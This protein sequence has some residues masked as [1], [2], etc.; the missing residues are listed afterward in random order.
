MGN[1]GGIETSD[2]GTSVVGISPF[3]DDEDEST[4][5]GSNNAS[6]VSISLPTFPSDEKETFNSSSSTTSF[7]IT[8]AESRVNIVD[9]TTTIAAI[10][11]SLSENEVTTT[12]WLIDQQ[13]GKN[14]E[15]MTLRNL[16]EK[17]RITELPCGMPYRAFRTAAALRCLLCMLII[18]WVLEKMRI[19]SIDHSALEGFNDH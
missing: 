13:L 2:E 3:G 1:T 12:Q 16:Y 11:S 5:T 6:K 8:T 7:S 14:F 18:H 9:T 19:E 10:T 4:S 15:V 17:Y